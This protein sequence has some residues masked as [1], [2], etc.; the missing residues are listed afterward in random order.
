[1]N[2]DAMARRSPIRRGTFLSERY[3]RLA[4]TT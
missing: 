3:N 1:V 2:S 4:E